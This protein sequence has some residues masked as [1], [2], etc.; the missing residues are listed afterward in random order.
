[1]AQS[2]DMYEQRLQSFDADERRD[3]VAALQQALVSGEI[4][5]AATTGAV[6]VHLHSFFSF[7]ACEYSPSR[8]VWEAKKI[9]LDVVGI[10]DF[11]VLDAMDELFAAAEALDIRAVAALESRVF[12]P[13]LAEEEINSPGEP[14]IAYFMGTGFT[15]LPAEG[16]PAAA[17]LAAMR[18]GAQERNRELTER[19][20]GVLAPVRIDYDRDVLP[21]SPAGNATERHMLAAIDAAARKHFPD[22]DMLTTYWAG[23]LRLDMHSVRVLLETKAK[24]LN[25]VRRRLMKKGGQAYVQPMAQTFPPVAD[26]VA[27][28]RGCEAVPCATWLDGTSGG[29]ADAR[30]YI[31]RMVEPGC[32]AFNIIPERNWNIDDPETRE[33]KTGKLAEAVEAAREAEMIFSVGTEMNSYGQKFVDSFDAPELAP[34]AEFFRDGAYILYGHTLLQRALGQG[35]TSAWAQT[36]FGGD[37]AAANRFYL[38]A[39]RHG[40]SVQEARNRLSALPHPS[41]PAAVHAALNA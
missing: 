33:L 16:T 18:T 10:V 23:R 22:S 2:V 38:Q 34:Y 29:E 28:I 6:N 8:I 20:N 11:D 25:T 39:A 24:F 15:A 27:M 7:N 12:M 5:A 19:L 4:A 13:M 41:D 9:G 37:R 32:L 26:V 1:M 14:G 35:L 40:C 21:L 3:A 31:A 30:D 17:T 36:A